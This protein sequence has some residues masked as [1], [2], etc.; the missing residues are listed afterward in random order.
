MTMTEES[1]SGLDNM[2]RD[3]VGYIRKANG[4]AGV[5]KLPE[6]VWTLSEAVGTVLHPGG[7]T[8]AGEYLDFCRAENAKAQGTRPATSEDALRF[9]HALSQARDCAAEGGESKVVAL[10]DAAAQFQPTVNSFDRSLAAGVFNPVA[11]DDR[12]DPSTTV[13][14]LAFNGAAR[15]SRG[16]APVLQAAVLAPAAL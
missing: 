9:R 2:S 5:L 13:T 11:R 7:F 8:S 6:A 1:K 10:I 4:L 12:R 16:V 14:G 15:D 3:L